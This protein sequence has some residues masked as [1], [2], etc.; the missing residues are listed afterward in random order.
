MYLR[1]STTLKTENE[2]AITADAIAELID[3]DRAIIADAL[4][5]LGERKLVARH[6]SGSYLISDESKLIASTKDLR[7]FLDDRILEAATAA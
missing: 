6:H 5:W 1:H 4:A 2:S 3:L 7:D